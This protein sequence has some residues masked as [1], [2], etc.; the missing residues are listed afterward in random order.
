MFYKAFSLLSGQRL[1]L[2]GITLSTVK[3]EKYIRG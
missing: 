2:A 3:K 1:M